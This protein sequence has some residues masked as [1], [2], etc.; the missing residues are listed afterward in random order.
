MSVFEQTVNQSVAGRALAAPSRNAAGV[1]VRVARFRAAM[2]G[3]PL[4]GGVISELA[5]LY[6][7][8]GL[9]AVLPLVLIQ[10]VSR[11]VG[12]EEWGRLALAESIGRYLTVAVEYGLQ[13]S[14]T[15]EAA[16]AADDHRVLGR[17]LTNVL[18]S[19]LF[20]AVISIP[21]ALIAAAHL[22]AG[23]NA[24]AL[25]AGAVVWGVAQAMSLAWYYQ[26]IRQIRLFAAIELTLK[27]LSV[28]GV[29]MIVR[30]PGQAAVALLGQAAATTA[31]LA[32]TCGLA[33]S[34]V[35]FALPGFGSILN[36]VRG[37]FSLFCFRASATLYMSLNVV[38]LGLYASPV[39]V[40]LFAAAERVCRLIQIGINPLNQVLYVRVSRLKVTNQY[41]A[42]LLARLSVM[43][44]GGV[45]VLGGMVM[46][47]GAPLIIKL[48]FGPAFAG[49]EPAMRCFGVVVALA[50][51]NSGIASAYL[52]PN[53]MDCVLSRA[54]VIGGALNLTLGSLLAKTHGGY[55]L[56]L[57]LIL[58][59]TVMLGCFC[60]ALL[61]PRMSTGSLTRR[62]AA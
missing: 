50:I 15:R 6:I 47:V 24:T 36:T 46:A 23:S 32:I 60:W 22:V 37:R 61:G 40:G 21:V 8:Q 5:W 44:M 51:L 16:A 41:K 12:P 31:A 14:G 3:N 52:L 7:I 19:Q 13:M 45:G 55:G 33:Y 34:K 27:T 54:S 4:E 62:G 18:S 48:L 10:H 26:A 42:A 49:T 17:V 43:V 35:T 25:T 58:V 30:H 11:I 38:L 28:I 59:E 20:I 29:C 9:T 56:S 2:S 1:R 39:E 57:S 53:N